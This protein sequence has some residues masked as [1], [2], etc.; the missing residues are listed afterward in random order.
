MRRIYFL[1]L[2]GGLMA[3]DVYYGKLLFQVAPP[4]RRLQAEVEWHYQGV[5]DTVQLWYLRQGLNITSM[6]GNPSIRR[7]ERNLSTGEVRV[8]LGQ[9]P[10]GGKGW[11]RVKY[12]GI[13][14]RSGFGS[15]E[16]AQHSTGWCLW[17]LSQP[18]GAPDWLFCRD[19]L[20]DK[21]DSLDIAVITPDTLLG[22]SN[23]RLVADSVSSTGWRWRHFRHRYPIAVYLIAIAA[24]N[25]VVQ[26]FPVQTPYHRFTLRNYVYPQDTATARQL[27]QTFLPYF[28]WLEERIG[29]YP[30]AAED[31]QQVQIGWRGGMEHQTITFFGT[32]SL[33]LWAHELGH[34]WFGDWVTCSSW[35]DI[36]INE[37]FGTYLGGTVFEVLN[38][39]IFSIWRR[40]ILRA[41]WRDTLNT[42]WV[43]DTS[44]VG[45]IFY[46][47]TTYAK[48][49]LALHMMREYVGEVAFWQGLRAFLSRHAGG[50]ASTQDF[51]RAVAPYWGS[52]ATQA[53]IL[54]W[55][56]TPGYP[57]A[58][59][60]WQGSQTA[61]VAPAQAYPMRLPYRAI[62]VTGD[63]LWEST[64]LMNNRLLGFPQNVIRLQLDPDTLTPY[65]RIRQSTPIAASL[66]FWPNPTTGPLLLLT[67]GIEEVRL[68]DLA[69]K[70]ILRIENPHKPLLRWDLHT[71]P[72]GIYI[73][74]TRARENRTE[75]KLILQ[76]P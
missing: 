15:F 76:T 60:H 40:N 34:Q 14:P 64:D 61:E 45:R 42:I 44:S 19:A 36:W 48:G 53:F 75:A 41:A 35:R 67:E 69:G 23:G 62:L 47:P 74:E 70:E 51:A 22:V 56:Y 73:L 13:P 7:Y 11:L 57:K 38:L 65:W 8:V 16:V 71:L 20:G 6:E 3:Q 66:A 58:Q 46:Y 50:F 39:P 32:Y 21:I 72:A 43:E 4:S 68:Y 52:V 49:A 26:E 33:E 5:Q 37:A 24:S 9:V 2:L 10:V 28:T 54:S 55:I 63:T 12:E 18:Y 30:F 27:S 25:Y 17:T 59:I 1:G 31:Y 29:P